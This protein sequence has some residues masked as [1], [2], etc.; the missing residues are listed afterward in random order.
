MDLTHTIILINVRIYYKWLKIR[1]TR[2][3]KENIAK[4]KQLNL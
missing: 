1:N 4:L 3:N 2:S